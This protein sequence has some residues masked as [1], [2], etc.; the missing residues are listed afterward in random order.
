MIERQRVARVLERLAD[1]EAMLGDPATR[2]NPALFRRRVREHA[3]LKRLEA[4]VKRYFRVLDEI[5][6]NRLLVG[7]PAGEEAFR[8]LAG[9]ELAALE[10]ELPAAERAVLAAMLPPDPADSR[11]AIIEIRAGTGGDEAGLFAGDLFRMYSRYCDERGWK[12]AMIDANAAEIGG[13]KEVVATIAGDGAYGALRFESGTHRV[14]RVPA[15]ESQGRIHTSA[16]TVLV[17]PEAEEE[18]ELDI[19]ADE[20]RIDIFCAGGH[21]GQGV[22]TTYSAV[23]ITHLPTGLVAQCQD[24][25]SQ[26][27]NREKAMKVL[28]ARILDQQRQNEEAASGQQRRDLVGSGDRSQKIRTYNFPQNRLTDHRINLTLHSLA[29]I[30][31]GDLDELLAALRN[32][33]FNQRLATELE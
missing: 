31:E 21:G 12:I 8:E 11:N 26:H 24:E 27:R 10:A 9:E 17:L 18:D 29:T 20:L 6:Q 32:H 3:G 23:R 22:N 28:Q 25:R 2:S 16:A 30:L 33:D 7:D 5:E 14:Q 15:T 1:I 13:Y 19:P 4:D